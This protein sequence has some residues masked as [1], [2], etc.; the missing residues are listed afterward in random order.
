MHKGLSKTEIQLEREIKGG[1]R[2][3]KFSSLGTARGQFYY[4][5]IYICICVATFGVQEKPNN[6]ATLATF[7]VAI[8]A[9][10]TDR[11]VQFLSFSKLERK[12]SF[13]SIK[14]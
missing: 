8:S 12:L 3:W 4:I 2:K 5:Y 9:F 1:A 6:P 14:F 13:F 11:S 10:F 7:S